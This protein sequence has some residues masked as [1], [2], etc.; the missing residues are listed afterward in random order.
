MIHAVAL[1]RLRFLFLFALESD[2]NSRLLLSDVFVDSLS[3]STK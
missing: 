1:I 3:Q 2:S